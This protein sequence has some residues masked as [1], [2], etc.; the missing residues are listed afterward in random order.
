MA[1]AVHEEQ[2][3][4]ADVYAYSDPLKAS[5]DPSALNREERLGLL[6]EKASEQLIKQGYSKDNIIIEKYL[7]LRYD[8]TDTAVM[9]K[10]PS[11][12]E[13]SSLPYA[14]AFNAHYTR[15]FGFILEGR[16]I[17]IDDYRVRAIV[18]GESPLPCAPVKSLGEPVT[19]GTTR[20]YF[21][22]GWKDANVYNT[23]E[24][25]AGHEIRGPAII[26]QSISTIVLEIGCHAYV[27]SDGDLEITVD[28]ESSS[29]T[30]SATKIESKADS[31][32]IKE[33]PV[34]LS[35]FSHRFMGIAEQ[36]GRTLQRTAISVNMK[37]RTY[38]EILNLC[39]QL[40][41]LLSYLS[42]LLKQTIIRSAWIFLVHCSQL[43]VA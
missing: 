25:K 1:D 6:G 37:V 2:E 41:A 21:E 12:E 14:D 23:K 22:N 29:S 19:S 40:C 26:V 31:N 39:L 32:D 18:P 34:Q 7:N 33:D 16:D 10:E 27:T 9:I 43:M 28:S 4:A 8:G 30:S 20:A 11:I 36:M 13:A 5:Q 3:P 24:L 17:I 15:E 35:I 38:V 42:F